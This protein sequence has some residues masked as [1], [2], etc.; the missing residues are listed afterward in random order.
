MNDG[1][2]PVTGGRLRAEG[3]H[4]RIGTQVLLDGVSLALGTGWTAVVGPN[5]AGKTSLLRALA[6]LLEPDAG[7]VWLDDTPLYAVRGGPPALPRRARAR[8]IGWLSQTPPADGDLTV[9]ETVALGRL[10]HRG[11]AGA[12]QPGD[13][14][15]IDQALAL[16]GC[17]GLQHRPVSQLSGGERQRAWLARALATGADVLLLDE[18]TTHLDPPHQV[19]LA[20]LAR[21]LARTHTVVSVVHDLP[22]A[23]A[24]DRLVLMADGRRVAEGPARDAALHRA[25]EQVFDGAVHIAMPDDG[26]PQ[27]LARW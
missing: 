1:S 14:Q 16:T 19:A 6:G 20:R 9:R 17:A 23:M 27:V 26:P 13:E 22:L 24:A 2:G 7:Q 8:R 10:P 3:L 21:Q 18:P 11:L 15:A 4:R 12:W 5:G 25:L